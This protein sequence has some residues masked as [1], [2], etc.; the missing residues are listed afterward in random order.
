MTTDDQLTLEIR[1]TQAGFDLLRAE[2]SQ[3]VEV[4][5]PEAQRRLH[6]AYES[7]AADGSSEVSDARW[8][9]DRIEQRIWR[10][11]DQLRSARLITDGELR[12][13]RV[14][15]GHRVDVRRDGGRECSYVLV[16]PLESDPRK[17]RLSSESPLG[18]ALL[19]GAVG[20]L[21]ILE[22]EGEPITIIG[23]AP[24]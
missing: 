2:L 20:D 10:L 24:G 17:R 6:D 1:L 14:A 22:P 7:G 16:S 18:K 4:A 23:L 3:L 9:H 21:V 13:D 19:G 8:E 5:R 12:S 15:L 11:D